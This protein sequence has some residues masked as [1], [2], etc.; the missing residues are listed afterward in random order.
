MLRIF[1]EGF[2]ILMFRF[3]R[4]IKSFMNAKEFQECLE[5]LKMF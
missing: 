1:Q 3:S 4:M 5:N 2:E